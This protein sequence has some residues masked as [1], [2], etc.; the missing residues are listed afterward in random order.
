MMGLFELLYYLGYRVKTAAD[1]RKQ[2]RLPARVVSIGNITTGGTGKTPVTMAVAR[3]ARRRG[4]R[5]CV[6][7]RG[8]RGRLEG[9][10][11]VTPEMS[12]ADAGDE[13]LLMAVKLDGIPVVKGKDRFGAGQFA[14]R[15]LSPRP[16]LFVLD[17]GFQ[18]RRL[19]RDVDVL[20]ISAH[21]PFDNWKLIPMGRLRE[22]V[23]RLSR[24]DVIVITKGMD[25]DRALIS[26][27][28][29]YSPD[30]PLFTSGY[31]ATGVLAPL[32]EKL[33]VSWLHGRD[34]YAFCGIGEPE[35]FRDFLVHLGVRLRGFKQYGD[36]HR[37]SGA[38]LNH[39]RKEAHMSGAPWIITT[40]K[41]IIR[42]QGQAVPDNLYTLA[43]EF[44]IDE[45]FYDE[46]F[47]NQLK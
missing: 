17:D 26:E 19:Y 44:V 29:K 31:R 23:G 2:R 25:E 35:S 13:P 45:A 11:V 42:L 4:M 33:P 40:E 5:P 38:D 20:L 22:P 36:H 21:N 1:I 3:E 30:S 8:Y 46:L 6:L 27:I 10:A 24:A 7:T 16:D 28:R 18:H 39:L 12:P 32:G 43:I 14:L 9:P 37:F 47:L 34:M 15:T 41:D